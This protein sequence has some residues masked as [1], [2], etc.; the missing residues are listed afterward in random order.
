M[1][2]RALPVIIFYDFMARTNQKI[3]MYVGPY[4]FRFLHRLVRENSSV[5]PYHFKFAQNALCQ[6]LI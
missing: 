3:Q 1:M 5:P 4:P 2:M 6:I